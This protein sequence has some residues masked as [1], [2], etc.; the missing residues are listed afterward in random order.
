MKYGQLYLIA[1]RWFDIDNSRVAIRVAVCSALQYRFYQPQTI[2]FRRLPEDLLGVTMAFTLG[3]QIENSHIG[4]QNILKWLS[5]LIKLYN[6]CS[7]ASW[8]I[9]INRRKGCK[10][11]LRAVTYFGINAHYWRRHTANDTSHVNCKTP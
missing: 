5:M 9:T 1:I 6:G 4:C 2:T 11:V 3:E 10:T 8:R 7:I